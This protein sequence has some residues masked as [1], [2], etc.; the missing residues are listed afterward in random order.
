[1]SHRWLRRLGLAPELTGLLFE[2]WRCLLKL[3]LELLHVIP[4]YTLQCSSDWRGVVGFHSIEERHN[5]VIGLM[6]A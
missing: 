5:F 3:S 1:M 6:N 4:K 2:W